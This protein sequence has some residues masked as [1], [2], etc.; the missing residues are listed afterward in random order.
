MSTTIYGISFFFFSLSRS[1]SLSHYTCF[2]YVLTPRNLTYYFLPERLPTDKY[3][4]NLLR[5]Q[6]PVFVQGMRWVTVKKERIYLKA[7]YEYTFS[8]TIDDS[9]M[10]QLYYT[11][12]GFVSN[13]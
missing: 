7:I 13:N 5:H 8:D 12:T 4:S 10:V 6:V 11:E 2:V 1:L 9:C 3:D